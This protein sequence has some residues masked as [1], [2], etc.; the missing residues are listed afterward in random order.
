[1][2]SVAICQQGD[3]RLVGG[4]T[5]AEGRVEFCHEGTWGTVCDDLWGNADAR[6]VCRQL[7]FTATSEF[8]FSTSRWCIGHVCF[9][10]VGRHLY[11]PEH[12]DQ[13]QL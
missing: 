1:M 3:L 2:L 10:I 11:K 13:T 12:S 6:V 8:R 4:S 9:T 5:A 7:G